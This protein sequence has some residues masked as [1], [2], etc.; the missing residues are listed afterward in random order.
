MLTARGQVFVAPAKQG[1]LVEVTRKTGVRY[2]EARFL[3]DGKSVSRALRRER[4]GRVLD[5]AGERRRQAR[6]AHERRQGA[7]LGGRSLARRPLDRPHDKNQQ[8]WLLDR[9]SR[10]KTRIA[11]LDLARRRF[12]AT[13]PG[14]RTASGSPT[15]AAGDNFFDQIKLYTVETGR[16]AAVTTDRYDS[17]SPAWSPDGK[18]LYFLSDRNLQP[19]VGAPWGPRQPEPFSD[20]DHED[21]SASR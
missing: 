18:W 4:R 21:L 11:D 12:P 5:V 20:G 15:S 2:R 13:S 8:L 9:K 7:A 14:R 6:A 17:D 10:K 3:P 19:L 1:R 16:T